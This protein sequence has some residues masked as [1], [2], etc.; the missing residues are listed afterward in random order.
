MKLANFVELIPYKSCPLCGST[1]FFTSKRADCSAYPHFRP[2][3]SS[4][5][6]WM[7]CSLCNHSFRNGF[8]TTEA[9]HFLFEKVHLNQRVGNDYERQRFLWARFIEKVATFR[10]TGIWLDVG[11]G[12]GALLLTAAEYG[13]NPVGIDIR[14]DNVRDL[15]AAGIPGSRLEIT[16]LHMEPKAAVISMCDVLEHM[17]FPVEA[18]SAAFRNL[19]QGGIL[20]LSMPNTSSPIWKQL[21]LSEQNPY[22]SEMEHFHNFSKDSLERVLGSCGFNPVSYGI[23][24]RYR[25]CMEIISVK[26]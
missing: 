7:Q 12:N 14:D 19:E 20:V 1:D 13:Y 5:L 3:L 22:W 26:K 6:I 10:R 23:S 21:D 16:D 24:E 2:P 15:V 17:Q 25:A 8:Y 18:V 9:F 4:N 11:F